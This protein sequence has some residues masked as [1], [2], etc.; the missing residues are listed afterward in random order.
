MSRLAAFDQ[1]ADQKTGTLANYLDSWELIYSPLNQNEVRFIEIL[2]SNTK[3][4]PVSCLLKA[5]ELGPGARYAALSYVWGD[6]KVTKD[7][8]VNGVVMSVTTNLESALRQLR[9]TGFPENVRS[10][11]VTQLWADAICINQKDIRERS[12]QVA[13]MASIYRNASYVYSWLGLPDKNRHDLAF[14]II[15]KLF[16]RLSSLFKPSGT[17]HNL[18]KIAKTGFEWLIANLEPF[19]PEGEQRE[20]DE[21]WA[22]VYLRENIYWSRMWII[23]EIALARDS[24][25]HCFICGADWIWDKQL[26]FVRA[27]LQACRTTEHRDLEIHNTNERI[28]WGYLSDVAL[29][30]LPSEGTVLS[31]F[32]KINSDSR[33]LVE[34]IYKASLRASATDPRDFVYAML[35]LTASNIQPDYTKSVKAVYLDAVLSDGITQCLPSCLAY[36]GS[37]YG[38]KNY[39]GI[40]S[41]LPDFGKVEKDDSIF[42]LG[43]RTSLSK[44]IQFKVPEVTQQ[45]TLRVQG[46]VYDFVESV[47]ATQPYDNETGPDGAAKYIQNVCI[48]YLADPV[49]LENMESYGDVSVWHMHNRPLLVLMDVLSAGWERDQVS[50]LDFDKSNALTLFW[51]RVFEDHLL[52]EE[53]ETTAKKRLRIRPHMTLPDFLAAAFAGRDIWDFRDKLDRCRDINS[54][55]MTTL[56]RMALRISRRALFRTRK[57]HLGLGPPNLRPGDIICALDRCPFSSLLR[58]SKSHLEHVGPC[59]VA[60]SSSIDLT[61]MVEKGE[62]KIEMFEI[63]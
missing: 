8:I 55:I 22:L 43:N 36:S 25:I 56:V 33:Q 19:S 49:V 7:I 4:A 42:I 17:G 24:S 62:L 50:L 47:H 20:C 34:C 52:T 2:P 29:L 37:G 63:Y 15:R 9:K 3:E 12:Q 14:Q 60:G 53:E 6:P 51:H 44:D 35:S 21:W 26:D 32:K 57:G 59:Y 16:C 5:A 48:E 58:K 39:N 61:T 28:I 41:W 27:F 54:T 40:P 1:A 45:D 30:G 38:Y 13:M 31:T 46:A 11:K 10:G 18:L 23:Q